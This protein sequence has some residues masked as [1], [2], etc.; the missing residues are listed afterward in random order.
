MKPIILLVE[1]IVLRLK[2]KGPFIASL[3]AVSYM[4]IPLLQTSFHK[5]LEGNMKDQPGRAGFIQQDLW[6]QILDYKP[7]QEVFVLVCLLSFL[8]TSKT[9]WTVMK[10]M[11]GKFHDNK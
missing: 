9:P 5:G 4:H 6:I 11:W 3:P 8:I 1:W 7:S 10:T 2:Q